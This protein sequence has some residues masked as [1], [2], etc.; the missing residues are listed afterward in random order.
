M[1]TRPSRPTRGE[2]E[3]KTSDKKQG[4]QDAPGSK[5]SLDELKLVEDTASI[6]L[7]G[8]TSLADMLLDTPVAL[9]SIVVLDWVSQFFAS[10]IV[11]PDP[12]SFA[13]SHLRS[14]ATTSNLFFRLLLLFSFFFFLLLLL[15]LHF[16]AAFLLPLLSPLSS[17]PL[18][19]SLLLLAPFPS[20]T[21]RSISAAFCDRFFIFES[22]RRHF[23]CICCVCMIGVF[24]DCSQCLGV[25]GVASGGR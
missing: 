21:T 5:W 8:L 14:H 7:D 4:R 20:A 2:G 11:L 3:S 17:R 15:F 13:Y 23:F 22:Y 25:G 12:F 6:S 1:Y 10:Q 24:W 18:D 16:A 19:P 9:I